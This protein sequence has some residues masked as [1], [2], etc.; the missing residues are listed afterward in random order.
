MNKKR[1]EKLQFSQVSLTSIYSMSKSS[2]LRYSST[3][4]FICFDL[5]AASTSENMRGDWLISANKSI[6]NGKFRSTP[7][8]TK[9][10][11]IAK[12]L[13]RKKMINTFKLG[14]E[15]SGSLILRGNA[16]RMTFR[17]WM[18]LE[19]ITSQKLKW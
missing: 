1:K 2:T 17:I 11:Y 9:I 8:K 18:Q 10:N 13:M 14:V 16:L 3:S 6:W 5:R 15:G 19:G 12:I 4:D 7:L